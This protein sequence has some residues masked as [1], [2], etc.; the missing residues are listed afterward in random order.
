MMRSP[1]A[2][3]KQKLAAHARA[4][5]LVGAGTLAGPKAAAVRLPAGWLLRWPGD[6]A[7]LVKPRESESK[8][9]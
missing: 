9:G 8:G 7:G 1:E 4:P 2:P 5:A 3:V 6:G